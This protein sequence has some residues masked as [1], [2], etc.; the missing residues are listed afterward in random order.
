[1]KLGEL[2]SGVIGEKDAFHVPGMVVCS[3]KVLK[4]GQS[5]KLTGRNMVSRCKDDERHGIVSIFLKDSIPVGSKF[6]MMIDPDLA[7]SE[8][9]CQR[10]FDSVE[11]GLN[12]DSCRGC[13]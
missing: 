11:E 8:I 3:D 13:Y 4:P 10:C 7:P 1:M 6:W 12:E 5:V 9:I 2:N